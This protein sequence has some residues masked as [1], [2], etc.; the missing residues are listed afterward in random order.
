MR[1]DLKE[2]FSGKELFLSILEL[3]WFTVAIVG[4]SVIISRALLRDSTTFGRLLP[5][6]LLFWFIVFFVLR[7]TIIHL[8]DF[9]FAWF[10]IT[11]MTF[12][13]AIGDLLLILL[14]KKSIHMLAL[15]VRHRRFFF[16][17]FE[18]YASLLH[19]ND[20]NEVFAASRWLATS[21]GTKGYEILAEAIRLQEKEDG[22][23]TKG[24]L[25][26]F[27]KFFTSRLVIF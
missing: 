13:W 14:Q 27:L 9:I 18:F 23:N 4:G 1:I 17:S 12:L 20:Q 7:S 2:I 26:D 8:G 19:S 5:L 16:R 11:V 10:E 6:T 24:P 25:N 21:G 22:K 3:L 15:N